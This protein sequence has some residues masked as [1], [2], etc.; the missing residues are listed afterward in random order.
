MSAVASSVSNA[1]T[2]SPIA[3]IAIASA[4]I[5][6]VRSATRSIPAERN[7]SACSAATVSR[8]ACSSPSGVKSIPSA[9]SPNLPRARSRSRACVIT[10][11]AR[12]GGRPL[13]PKRGSEGECRVGPVGGQG[14]EE[15]EP[16]GARRR[17]RLAGIHGPIIPRPARS[18]RGVSTRPGRVL[19]LYCSAKERVRLSAAGPSPATEASPRRRRSSFG[20]CRG[21]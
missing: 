5:P 15:G 18:R 7:R 9:N 12:E 6:A 13:R 1:M 10:A 8:V 4:P 21:R 3:D 11:A 16:L 20:T 17:T 14:V 2:A 19:S